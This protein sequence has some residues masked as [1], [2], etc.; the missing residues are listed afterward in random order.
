MVEISWNSTGTSIIGNLK[1]LKSDMMR[2][3]GGYW[4]I[5]FN[6]DK[7]NNY[8]HSCMGRR[9]VGVIG[10]INF[11]LMICKFFHQ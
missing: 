4:I 3:K 6:F 2:E 9:N 5:N 11:F 10:I 1:I 7:K 8:A